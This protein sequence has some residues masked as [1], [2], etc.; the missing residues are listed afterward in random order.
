MKTPQSVPLP[1]IAAL[2]LCTVACLGQTTPAPMVNLSY[3]E[4]RT[5]T[6]AKIGQRYDLLVSLLEDYG[7]PDQFRARPDVLGPCTSN[8]CRG[9]GQFSVGFSSM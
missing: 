7:R 4:Q 3:T 2:L 9:F 1:V 5:L 8:N 6:S